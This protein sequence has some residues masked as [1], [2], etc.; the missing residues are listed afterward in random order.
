MTMNISRRALLRNLSLSAGAA[1]LSPVMSPVLAQLKAQAAG[2]AGGAK[3]FVFVVEGN[4]LPWQQVT[5][6]EVSRPRDGERTRL[7]DLAMKDLTLPKSLEP[8]NPWKD[9]VS[10]VNGLSGKVCGGGHSNNFGALGCYHASGGVGNSGQAKAETIDAALGK[11]LGGI[12]PQVGLGISDRAEHNVIYNCSAWDKGK[13]LPTTC[14]PLTA[15]A[16]LFG[17][18]AGGDAKAQFVARSNVLDFL[19][20]DIKRLRTQAGAAEKDKLEAHLEAY[21]T[22]R[23]RQSRLN[24]VENTLRKHAPVANDKFRSEVEADRLDAH[25]DIAAAAL[26]GGLT[27]V[28]TLASG[29][30]DPYLSVKWGGLGV[31]VGKHTLGHGGNA[32]DMTWDQAEIVIRRFHFELIARLMKKMQA[33]PEGNGTML[34]NTVIV[35]LSDAAEGHHSRCWEWPFVVVGNAGGKLRGGR[36][37]EYPYWG[38]PGHREIGNLY[39]TLLQTV[40]E[41]RPYFGLHEPQLKGI[42]ADGPLPELLA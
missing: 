24:E 37:I 25:F 23:S 26:I 34:D 15:Y 30:G 31:S 27:N 8:L 20:D 16:N 41:T 17:S 3:R 29:V 18:V 12:F 5:P 1:A 21:E 22:L 39:T 33:V 19:T 14:H 9:R 7:I 32:G 35:Y 28:V 38:K 11:K 6:T 2:A 42:G 10:V 36:Y 4:G 40:G 13:A